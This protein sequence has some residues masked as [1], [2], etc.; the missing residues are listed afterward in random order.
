METNTKINKEKSKIIKLIKEGKN[1][2]IHSYKN[3]KNNKIA[4]CKKISSPSKKKEHKNKK[5]IIQKVFIKIKNNIHSSKEHKSKKEKCDSESIMIF[6][7]KYIL[8][9]KCNSLEGAKNKNNIKNNKNSKKKEENEELSNFELNDLDYYDAIKLDKRQFY[10]IYL[11]ILKR[12]HIIYFTFLSPNDYNLIYVKLAKFFFFVCQDMAMNV[13]FFSDDSMHKLYASYG[14]YD[15]IYQIPKIIYSMLISRFIESFLDYLSSTD[16]Y[17]YQIKYIINRKMKK[18]SILEVFKIAKIKL[19]IFFALTFI[20]YLFY[21]Y[22]ISAFCAVF[23]N[24]QIP[25]IKDSASSFFTGLA[26]PFAL[27]LLPPFLRIISLKN[28]KKK[29]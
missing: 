18:S 29:D 5:P 26:Y 8:K 10:Q 23:Q 24:T 25:F 16:K 11:S 27:Y 19:F 14:K 20:L 2:K 17:F 1:D 28:D 7:K 4:L 15:F 6:K 21:W 13:I 9:E 3:N 12:E 22:F